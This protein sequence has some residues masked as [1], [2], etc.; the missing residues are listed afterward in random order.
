[1]SG[2]EFEDLDCS[3]VIADV[4]TLLDNECDEASRQ[5]VQRHL[6][7]C[8]SCLAQYGIEEKIKSLVGRKCGGE[9][10]PEGLRE[11]LTLEIR[12]S[13]TITATED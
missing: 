2:N 7:S 8:G 6:D 11:R 10:A 3:A 4:W 1:M 12:R 9:R 5:R 13:V